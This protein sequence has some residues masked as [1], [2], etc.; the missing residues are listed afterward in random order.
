V[1]VSRDGQSPFFRI[2]GSHWNWAT[3]H[4]GSVARVSTREPGLGLGEEFGSLSRPR[5]SQLPPGFGPLHG[6]HLTLSLNAPKLEPYLRTGLAP[7]TE[8]EV[9]AHDKRQNLETEA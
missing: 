6:F 5:W 9:S 7:S 2:G 1:I 8:R 4:R 3:F